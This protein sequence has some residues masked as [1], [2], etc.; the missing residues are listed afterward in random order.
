MNVLFRCATRHV[1]AGTHTIA[2]GR[3]VGSVHHAVC[4]ERVLTA[5]SQLN[6]AYFGEQRE[7]LRALFAFAGTL[8][9]AHTVTFVNCIL[10]SIPPELE[11]LFPADRG[12]HIHRFNT[13]AAEHD[14]FIEIIAHAA[15]KDGCLSRLRVG[16]LYV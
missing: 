10:E 5:A 8:C 3:Q 11:E 7:M 4:A 2:V 9:A 12:L 14:K 6:P 16:Q 15:H 1:A 13:N